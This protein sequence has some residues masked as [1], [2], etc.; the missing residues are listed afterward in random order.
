MNISQQEWSQIAGLGDTELK[1]KIFSLIQ[2]AALEIQT[3]DADEPS[4]LTMVPRLAD[5]IASRSE[6]ASF[7][8]MFSALARSVGLWNYIDKDHADA[9]D[10]LVAE[11]VTSE[12]LG[13]LT[14]HRE[15]IAALNELLSGRNLVLSAPTSFGKSILIDALLASGKYRRVAI[16]LPTIALLDEFR[17]RLY[18]RFGDSFRL[19]MYHS[20]EATE[21]NVIFLGT[22]ER[23]I[24]RKDLGNLDLVVVDEF[25]KLDPRRRDDRSLTLNAAVYRLLRSA[26]QFFFLGPNIEAVRFSADSRWRFEFLR[27]RFSTVAV[28]TFDL[29][30]VEDKESR[31]EAEVRRETNWPALIFVSSPDRANRL[32]SDLVEKGLQVGRGTEFSTWI[33]RNFGGRWLLSDAVASGIGVHHGRIPRAVASQS[34]RLFNSGDLPLLICTST[35]IEGVNTAAKS[36][37]I[38][39]KAINREDFDFFTFSNIRGR[40]GRLGTHH[41]GN[42]YLFHSPPEQSEIEVEPPLFGDLDDAPDEL[43][44]HITDEDLSSAVSGRLEVLANRLGLSLEQL[45]LASSVG[46]EAA[47]RLREVTQDAIRAGESLAWSGW[48]RWPE[49][50]ATCKAICRVE[51]PSQF[52]VRSAQQLAFYLGRLRSSASMLRFFQWHSGSYQGQPA[53]KDNVFKFLRACEYGLPQLFAL[54]EVFAQQIADNVDYSLFVAELPRWFRPEVL[55]NLDEQGIPIQISERFYMDGDDVASLSERLVREARNNDAALSAFERSW[56]MDA[57]LR[58]SS[59]SLNSP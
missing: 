39:D 48:P 16:V 31:L 18:G 56:I 29:R 59:R 46:I 14:F 11:A 54:T 40:A 35:L 13:G 19:V 6:L 7:A 4:L 22:Q 41:V 9:R 8:E 34:I 50:L 24:N 51:Q 49:I 43:V 15:Q 36:V 12:E 27:T 28:D 38:F 32:A 23:L 37:L 10:K 42:V 21:G 52:G 45:R 47:E 20:E 3:G 26:R 5:L 30:G 25:Y 58:G 1:A 17:R 53:D 55:K 44:V 33:E 57:M 2:G